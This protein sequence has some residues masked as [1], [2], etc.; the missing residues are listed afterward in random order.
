VLAGSYR[1][2]D[3]I[4]ERKKYVWTARGINRKTLASRSD[5]LE[6]LTPWRPPGWSDPL[7][8]PWTSGASNP[9]YYLVFGGLLLLCFIIAI[10]SAINAK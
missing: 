1:V 8:T 7:E 9:S 10:V 2:H 5:P 3:S 6:G 4:D